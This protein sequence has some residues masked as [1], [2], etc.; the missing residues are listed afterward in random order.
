MCEPCF[1]LGIFLLR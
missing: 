1:F